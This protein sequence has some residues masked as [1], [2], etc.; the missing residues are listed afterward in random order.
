MAQ[1]Q[2][3]VI[4]TYPLINRGCGDYHSRRI[5]H[6]DFYDET[7]NSITINT[8]A[9]LRIADQTLSVSNAVDVYGTLELTNTAAKLYCTYMTWGNGST[10]SMS[11]SSVISLSR[12]WEF[13]SGANINFTSGYV[14]FTGTIA[15]YITSKDGNCAFN[16]VRNFKSATY[17]AHSSASTTGSVING[18]LY[19]YSGSEL[20]SFS[21]QR[22][23][24]N[25]FLNNI[26]GSIHLD[27]GIFEFKGG[28]TTN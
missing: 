15:S 24:L 17:L 2:Q 4:G 19:M 7:C 28:F 1:R 12:N 26:A 18:N 14:D 3:L 25:G 5:P 10:G 6:V 13:S 22:I 8:G 9:T 20:R 23:E 11:G 16:H 27:S 21:S